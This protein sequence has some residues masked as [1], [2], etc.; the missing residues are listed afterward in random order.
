MKKLICLIAM[1]VLIIGCGSKRAP[2]WTKTAF[3]QLDNYK[4]NYLMGKEQMAERHFSHAIEEIKKSGD[5]DVLA[6]AYLTKNAV[7]VAVLERI[8][9]REFLRID[10]TQPLHQ[11][12]SFHKFLK[13][14]MA[15]VEEELMPGQYRAFFRAFQSGRIDGATDE[16]VQMEDPLSRLI[17]TGLVVHENQHDERCLKVAIDTASRNGWKKALL[18]YLEK[19][20]S[21]YETKNEVEKAGIVRNRIELIKY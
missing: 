10:A 20:Q 21:Y 3:N 18:A 16:I 6:T 5:L 14:E 9:D 8:D 2:D 4:K 13:G 19:L 11:H 15:V 1:G 17:A 12:R 7:Q